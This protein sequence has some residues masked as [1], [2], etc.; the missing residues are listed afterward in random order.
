VVFIAWKATLELLRLAIIL[1]A[2]HRRSVTVLVQWHL[3]DFARS[4][5]FA[6]V[7]V[8]VYDGNCVLIVQSMVT[9]FLFFVSIL[10]S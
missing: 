5:V 9:I 6:P 3:L 4:S 7:L 2:L 10:P 8:L 1:V